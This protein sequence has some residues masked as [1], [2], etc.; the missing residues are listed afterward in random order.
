MRHL[1]NYIFLI[2]TTVLLPSF[3]DGQEQQ[4]DCE[5]NQLEKDFKNSKVL[6]EKADVALQIADCLRE[7]GDTTYLKWYETIIQT[8]KDDMVKDGRYRWET[9]PSYHIA[10]SYYWLED[11]LRSE[12][13][14]KKAIDSREEREYEK[15][16]YPFEA[17]RLLK[18]YS[19]ILCDKGKFETAQ[20]TIM[21]YEAVYQDTAETEKLKNYCNEKK[22]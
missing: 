9:K 1:K 18:Y 15:V 12:V 14:L 17:D 7:V 22:K 19:K 10:I 6:I 8:Y 2:L 13:W 11:S 20:K 3:S 4:V 5:I 16:K 21:E